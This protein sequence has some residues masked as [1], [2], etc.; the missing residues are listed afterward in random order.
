MITFYDKTFCT[1]RECSK[2]NTCG[3]ALTDDVRGRAQAWWGGPNPPISCFENPKEL[4][5]YS[6]NHETQETE[7]NP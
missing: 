7:T 4:K 1:A 5:C 3:R 6:P 2:F